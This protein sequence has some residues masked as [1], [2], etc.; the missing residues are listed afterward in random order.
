MYR[1]AALI[2][3]I[4]LKEETATIVIVVM[5]GFVSWVLVLFVTYCVASKQARP[6]RGL[7]RIVGTLDNNS[8][9]NEKIMKKVK[10]QT[11]TLL[12]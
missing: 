8:M 5:T 9:H 4:T 1:G 10:Q 2:E 12:N 7:K 6:L 3:G 11:E